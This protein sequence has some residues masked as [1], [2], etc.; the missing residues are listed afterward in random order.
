MKAALLPLAL[1][2]ALS[3]CAPQGSFPSLSPR[4]A[5]YE[6][7]GREAPPCIAGAA[8]PAAAPD[9]AAA[10]VE[11]AQLAARIAELVGDARRGQS[12]FEEAL[13]AAR[14]A[15]GRAGA[16][17]SES[18]IAAQQALSRLEAAQAP[19]V[20]AL[21]ELEALVLSRSADTSTSAPDRQR[22]LDVAE[23][24]R[25]IAAAQRTEI[26]A[27]AAALS[28]PSALRH[29]PLPAPHSGGRPSAA[30]GGLAATDRAHI[31]PAA[32]PTAGPRG[33]ACPA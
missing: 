30:P 31:S 28:G 24:V 21:A 8:R 32:P 2:A 16:S 10:P 25:L 33:S 18:W 7:T 11:D 6:L 20:N 9:G 12:E 4:A 17:G 27:I 3:A 15:A 23:E 1:G 5:E 14:R 29:A 19:T 13:P 22:L 26:D